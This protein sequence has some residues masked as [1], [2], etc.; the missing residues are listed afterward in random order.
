MCVFITPIPQLGLPTLG[1]FGVG[2]HT[3]PL[4]VHFVCTAVSS[5]AYTLPQGKLC[6]AYQ[7]G[8]LPHW[9]LGLPM[10]ALESLAYNVWSQLVLVFEA[11]GSMYDCKLCSASECCLLWCWV[12]QC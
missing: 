12:C 6:S 5:E 3:L 8:A 7:R 9:R 1:R 10:L 4:G 2:R 11:L